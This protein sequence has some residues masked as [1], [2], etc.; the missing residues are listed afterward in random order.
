MQNQNNQ[1][2]YLINNGSTVGSADVELSDVVEDFRGGDLKHVWEL[3]AYQANKYRFYIKSATGGQPYIGTPQ[4]SANI[5]LL[6]T[7]NPYFTFSE[8]NGKLCMK[9]SVGN[10]DN[11]SGDYIN[12]YGGQ[13]DMVAGWHDTSSG[14][15]FHL[16]PIEK[17]VIEPKFDA[18]IELKTID[19]QTAVVTPVTQINRN[20]FINV[21]VTVAYNEY[22]GKFKFEVNPWT[23]KNEE[24]TYE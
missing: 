14:S 7:K 24:I 4:R 3:E 18:D 20:D 13:Q 8:N 9:S 19:A 2:R 11:S 23:T 5:S 22:S 15:Q 16:Y 1:Y 10:K 17:K 6:A 12:V 21:L